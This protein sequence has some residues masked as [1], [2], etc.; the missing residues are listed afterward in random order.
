MNDYAHIQLD[1]A[2]LLSNMGLIGLLLSLG[3]CGFF[4]LVFKRKSLILRLIAGL[5]LIFV[6]LNVSTL[7]TT[8]QSKEGIVVIAVDESYSNTINQRDVQ[9]AEALQA[10]LAKIEALPQLK[11]KIIRAPA[12]VNKYTETNLFKAIDKGLSDIPPEQRS[13]VIIISD[14][15]IH[16]VPV[17]LN[18]AEMQQ[19]YGP[20]H[21]VMTGKDKEKDRRLEIKKAPLYGL[22]GTDARIEFVIHDT[23]LPLNSPVNLTL[24]T[25]DGS[26][27]VITAQI[28][29]RQSVYVPIEHAG[30]NPIEIVVDPLKG[31]ISQSNNRRA[32][33]IQ[34]IRDKLNVL[35]VSGAP[36][37]GGRYWRNLLTSDPAV[38]LVHFTI[39]R[40]IDSKDNTARNEMALIPFPHQ[41]LFHEQLNSFDLII[42]DRY[43]NQGI[44]QQKTYRN[45]ARY[46]R[47]GGGVLIASGPEYVSPKSIYNT[48]F[49]DVLIGSPNKD[50]IERPFKPHLSDQGKIHPI[51][52]GIDNGLFTGENW[53]EWLR[54]IDVT[55]NPASGEKVLMSGIDDRPLLLIGEKD[56]GRIIHLTSD[57]IWLW[58]RQYQQ[59][60]PYI[61]LM[62]KMI[63]WLLKE[64]SL[65]EGQIELS[66]DQDEIAVARYINP[67]GET[68][69]Y[70]DPD[71]IEKPLPLKQGRDKIFHARIDAS[72]QGLYSFSA[73]KNTAYIIAGAY[74]TLEQT[75]LIR[76]TEIIQPALSQTGGGSFEADKL[77]DTQFKV[78]KGT[79]AARFSS[80]R[81]M[82][83]KE[84]KYAEISKIDFTPTLPLWFYLLIFAALN[85]YIWQRESK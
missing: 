47:K 9:T 41:Q 24:S 60:G 14:G 68:L 53:A 11:A 46:V 76:S 40:D 57:Q 45:L 8:Q 49:K 70:T 4:C 22:K 23:V 56:N 34:G 82:A 64:P 48:A 10:T 84:S 29:K 6:V 80:P 61:D 66:L 16:D 13:G 58:A 73:G 77:S 55:S 26:K 27:R 74:D 85:V 3:I 17:D 20:I 18:A 25:P 19:K 31:E 71:G 72:K 50:S 75:N 36:H 44:L 62:R 2:P 59:G 81:T 52:R 12:A 67:A 30:T 38:E 32:V 37:E 1:F 63:H 69:K 39:L 79:S 54:Q 35:L 78:K 7:S 28:G 43:R 5:A 33:I 15:N 65:E 51:T 21:L 42:F 83:F